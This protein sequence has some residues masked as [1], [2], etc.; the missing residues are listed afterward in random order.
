MPKSKKG[1]NLNYNKVLKIFRNSKPFVQKINNV[2]DIGQIAH[3][4]AAWHFLAFWPN[5]DGPSKIGH[6]CHA[7]ECIKIARDTTTKSQRNRKK[8]RR[9]R[10]NNVSKSHHSSC[11]V[12]GYSCTKE[13]AIFEAEMQ[14]VFGIG[15]TNGS[16]NGNSWNK[17]GG[18]SSFEAV[19]SILFKQKSLFLLSTFSAFAKRRET[20]H[21]TKVE[22]FP[23]L[24]SVWL[25]SL[26]Q[27][28]ILHHFET[29][30]FDAS[31]SLNLF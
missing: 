23:S 31:D 4:N 15:S 2:F 25:E 1:N 20:L 17:A 24:F 26:F 21:S 5:M 12:I 14:R 28:K 13:A 7:E 9:N 19:L 3:L 22:S 27:F 11:K 18:L 16:L 29:A 8:K 10:K 30:F 6:I